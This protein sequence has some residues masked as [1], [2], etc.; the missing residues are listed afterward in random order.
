MMGKKIDEEGG[1][2]RWGG[3]GGCCQLLTA[4]YLRIVPIYNILV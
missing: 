4:P 3:G 1:I 2:N